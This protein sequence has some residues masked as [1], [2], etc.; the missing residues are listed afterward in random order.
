MIEH[1]ILKALVSVID[2]VGLYLVLN[3]KRLVTIMGDIEIKI[4]AVSLG[5]AAAELISTHFLDIIF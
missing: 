1:D 3:A 2:V 5:W 4:L